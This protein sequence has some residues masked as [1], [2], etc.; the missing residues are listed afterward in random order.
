[1]K[2]I[3]KLVTF[4]IFAISSLGSTYAADASLVPSATFTLEIKALTMYD[5]TSALP[6]SKGVL[7]FQGKNYPFTVQALTMGNTVGASTLK[8][9]G[10]VY[11]MKEVSQFESPFFLIGG[12]INPNDTGDIATYKNANGVICVMTGTL[13]G[14][15]WAPSTGAIIK[16]LK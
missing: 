15:L 13:N 16:L 1:M 4:F 6:T 12:G 9:T 8:A 3:F 11:G 5:G 10:V 2:K 14:P 7:T